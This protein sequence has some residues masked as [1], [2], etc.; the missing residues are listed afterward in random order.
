M[1]NW[2]MATNLPTH[3]LR[4]CF[5]GPTRSGKTTCCA[6]FPRPIFIFPHNEGSKEVI[7]GRAYPLVE[8]STMEDMNE[9]LDNLL[10]AQ[11]GGT[12]AD[13]GNTV[14]IENLATIP[15]W[16]KCS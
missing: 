9:A 7:R 3:Y 12:L 14:C 16:W 1:L 13:W 15:S 11:R 2:Q 6:T 8:V 10:A 4:F 5:Y